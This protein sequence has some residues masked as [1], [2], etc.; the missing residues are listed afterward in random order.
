MDLLKNESNIKTAI[1]FLSPEVLKEKLADLIEII[2]VLN[3]LSG[4]SI[5]IHVPFETIFKDNLLKG[6]VKELHFLKQFEIDVVLIPQIIPDDDNYVKDIFKD[7]AHVNKIPST[8]LYDMLE[9]R[10]SSKLIKALNVSGCSSLAI[11]GN[12]S[13]SVVGSIKTKVLLNEETGVHEMK[14]DSKYAK[15]DF[16]NTDV[17][18]D[19]L[20]T[21]IMPVILPSA[22]NSSGNKKYFV[23]S[24]ELASVISH[25]LTAEKLIIGLHE[26][27]IN[28]V[29]GNLITAIGS[30]DTLKFNNENLTYAAEAVI[31]DVKSA[32]LI[33][34]TKEY[35]LI[36][37]VFTKQGSGTMVYNNSNS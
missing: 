33:N 36:I 11:S 27:G 25:K 9:A 12:E 14:L 32:H 21:D 17:I 3:S 15:I 5:V 6:F 2:P 20:Q 24:V 35:S 23:N 4:H 37:E 8:D 1:N 10:L 7:Q 29:D 19:I 13:M 34:L 28:D 22:S 18:N 16:F 30:R 26:D 31:N